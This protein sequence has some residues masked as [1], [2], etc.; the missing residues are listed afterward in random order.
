MKDFIKKNYVKIIFIFFIVIGIVIRIYGFPNTIKEMNIDEIITAINA[1]LLSDTG[2][3]ML[4]QSFP[5]YIQGWGG[6]SVV[7]SYLIAICMKIFGFTLFAVRLPTLIV[8][9]ISL[10]V[11]Y[12]LLKKI[13]GNKNI[14][15]I[16]LGI[17]AISPWHIIQSLFT[18]DCNMFPH[19]LLF[20]IDIFYTGILKNKKAI[21]YLSMI[22]F[23]IT[24]YCYGIAIYFVPFFLLGMAIYLIKHKKIK[25]KDLIICIV[26]FLI[27]ALPIIITF[28]LNGFGI[29][30]TITIFN[31]TLP[32]YKD[33][34]RTSDM[35][36]FS[37]NVLAQL[38]ENIVYMFAVLICQNDNIEWNT[39][40][41]FGTIYHITT[42]F[43]ILGII[44]SIKKIKDKKSNSSEFMI[45]LWFCI[46]I[47]TGI[48]INETTVNR[49]NSI[50]YVLLI[51]AS[52]GIYSLYEM[53][54]NK[55]IYKY[56]LITVYTVLFILF[57]I[58]FY[59]YHLERIDQSSC[60]SKGFYQS[61]TYVKNLDK[62]EVYYDDREVRG[63][64]NYYI[65]LNYDSS[66]EYIRLK[67][68]EKIKEKVENIEDDEII[69]VNE[70]I[71]E[72]DSEY[73]KTKIGDFAII[74]K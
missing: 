6:Q 47:L 8:S 37:D 3:D 19:F 2:K 60:F 40:P 27:F 62:N 30:K 32:Y 43:S 24:L 15:L 73:E 23:A 66:K 54:K 22:F 55:K 72:F 33:L 67:E 1:K 56:V 25:I 50:W 49:L 63:K 41:L 13:S 5:V 61:L 52:I 16:G 71:N 65:V 31:I 46:S 26:I 57:A 44:F 29:E 45:I 68:E 34:G 69:I 20:A 70:T 21:I 58:Y 12:D 18:L 53:I 10:F 35:I 38:V 59:T 39:T 14:A 11:F 36:F 4:G 64:L 17:L 51:F 42:V 28:V 7:I 48:I 9:I 74:Y